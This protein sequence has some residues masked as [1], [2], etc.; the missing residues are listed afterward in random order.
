MQKRKPI[1]ELSDAEEAS[2]QQGIAGDPDN[3][4]WTAEDFA[5]AKPFAE[6]FPELA[7]SIQDDGVEVIGDPTV[8]KVVALDRRVIEK[9]ESEGGDWQERINE[10]LRKAVGL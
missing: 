7:K 1:P 8:S 5:N 2:I 10:I 4:E 6:V 9:F 3:P